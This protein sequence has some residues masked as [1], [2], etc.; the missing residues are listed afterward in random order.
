[1]TRDSY[2]WPLLLAAGVLTYL[3]A[4]FDILTASFPSLD[5]AWEARIELLSGLVAAVSGVA[6]KSPLRLSDRGKR[7]Y[8]IKHA[9]RDL[10]AARAAAP[11]RK[12]LAALACC[13]VGV[14]AACATGLKPRVV[15]AY[16]ATEIG[17]G[18][19]QDTERAL[20]AAGTVPQLTKEVHEQRISPAF[21]VA[22]DAQIKF[23]NALLAWEPGAALPSG[24]AEW[25]TSV[26]NAVA[27]LGELMPR[28][29]GVLDAVM[30]WVT[31]VADTIRIL[32]QTVPPE[33]T[34]LVKEQ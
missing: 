5:A 19:V 28:N 11:T 27:V 10:D 16:Q 8:A 15:A 9:A 7:H 21:V 17:L 31:N 18:A 1:M 25:V 12:I 23:G 20:Y 33:L 22:F 34:A 32:G 30:S 26:Q 29:K 24:Y 3:G 2:A 6:W 14:A 13:T 4:H